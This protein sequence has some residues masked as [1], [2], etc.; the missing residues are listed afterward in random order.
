MKMQISNFII[1]YSALLLPIASHARSKSFGLPLESSRK[2]R[3]VFLLSF[4]M[5]NFLGIAARAPEPCAT[6]SSFTT[7][8]STGTTTYLGTPSPA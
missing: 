4:M 1:D 5:M 8:G 3:L 2:L 6:C 7:I